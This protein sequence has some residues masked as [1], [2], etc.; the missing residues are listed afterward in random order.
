ME[1]KCDECGKKSKVC[2]LS[3]NK[4]YKLYIC[5]ECKSKEE[6]ETSIINKPSCDVHK[7]KR[8]IAT[9]DGVKDSN[10]NGHIGEVKEASP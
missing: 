9:A 1:N 3:N 8:T 6:N 4:R 7:A 5:R 10:G 2:Y